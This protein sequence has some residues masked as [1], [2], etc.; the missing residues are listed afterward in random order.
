MIYLV[1][2]NP[3]V[4]KNLKNREFNNI[5]ESNAAHPN[6][7]V[8]YNL[9]HDHVF[10]YCEMSSIYVNVLFNSLQNKPVQP[11]TLHFLYETTKR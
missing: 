11:V 10:N 8:T 3:I 5:N 9:F 4:H 7:C 6:Y 2:K 1:F